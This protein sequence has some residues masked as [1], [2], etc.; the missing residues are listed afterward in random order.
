MDQH[1]QHVRR[2]A[3]APK[4]LRLLVVDDHR[5]TADTLRDLLAILFA[6][7]VRAAYGVGEALR[8]AA[9]CRPDDVIMYM[10]MP[11]ASGF[12]LAAALCGSFPA[13]PPLMLAMS[14]ND[15]LLAV[16][17]RNPR[18]AIALSK[19]VAIDELQE[20]LADVERRSGHDRRRSAGVAPSR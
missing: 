20:A 7:E 2:S 18:F 11:P 3:A 5:D 4:S 15:D 6:C 17:A 1:R 16:A 9:A 19:P 8:E 12:E 13:H 14:G 10:E